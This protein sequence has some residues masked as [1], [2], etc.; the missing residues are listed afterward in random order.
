MLRT[1]ILPLGTFLATAMLVQGC[2][3]SDSSSG[4][5]DTVG[6]DELG[7]QNVVFEE[8]AEL[9][10]PDVLFYD[11]NAGPAAAPIATHA[12]RRE[13]LDVDRT[14]D[15]HIE[16]DGEGPAT[17][18]VLAKADITGLL[19]LW[20]CDDSELRHLTKDFYD[21]AERSMYFERTR[22]RTRQ[23]RGWRLVALSGVLLQSENTTRN[24]D[25]VR[26][27]AG[28]VDVTLDDPTELYRVEDVLRLP[29]GAE[30]TVTVSTGDSTDAVFL[31]LKH[32][33]RR[34]ELGS[35]DDGT[36][37]GTYFTTDRRG[38]RHL[39]VDVLSNGTLYDD[40]APYDNVAW[41]FPYV[42][43]GMD[44]AGSDGS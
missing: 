42:V 18:E 9:A 11:E 8:Q 4:P 20:V 38:P 23:H 17:A 1:S 19:H 5:A 15:I 36:F 24:I 14:L 2:L 33:R 30:V 35:N 40:T 10:D 37:S 3:D 32:H 22:E 34:L 12:W 41:G 43:G 13:V 25:W 27:Q 7:I 21:S 44:D 28:D 16:R 26:V 31:H 39:V 6:E 29:G